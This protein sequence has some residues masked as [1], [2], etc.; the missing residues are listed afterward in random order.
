M[1][2]RP[3]VDVARGGSTTERAEIKTDWVKSVRPLMRDEKVGTFIVRTRAERDQ[4]REE[5]CC[6]SGEREQTGAM[7]RSRRGFEVTGDDDRGWNGYKCLQRITGPLPSH[8]VAPQKLR[9]VQ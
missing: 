3:A 7:H 9:A 4:Y 1:K 8:H 2:S 6:Q 5:E